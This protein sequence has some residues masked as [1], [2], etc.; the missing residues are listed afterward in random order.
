[1]VERGHDEAAQAA[2]EARALVAEG[3]YE[4]VKIRLG[5]P[6]LEEDLAVL[7][8]V[9]EAVGEG[10]LLPADFNQGLTVMEAVRRGRAL[11][12]EGV[13]WIEEPVRYD[14]L[15]GSAKVAR[16]VATP[17]QIGEN[18]YGP[19][20]VADAIAKRAG[21]WLMFD[22]ARVGGVT[23]WLRA[24]ALAEAAGVEVSSH[25]FP[26][27]SRHLMA[28]TPTRHWLEFVDWAAPILTDPPRVVNGSLAIPEAPGAGI[29]WD[30]DAVARYSV[31]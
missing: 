26:E 3:D 11:D 30:E 17:I 19:R 18:L 20:A 29:E 8:S 14:D 10:T 4:A 24:A 6:T 21:D 7:R 23:G 27:F 2:E 5:R 28:V 22:A 31:G 16:E 12:A 15:D 1:M 25:L 9:R 13:Y